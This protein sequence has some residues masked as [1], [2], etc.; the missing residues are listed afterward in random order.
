M[1]VA[2]ATAVGQSA[3][4]TPRTCSMNTR[5][6][7]LTGHQLRLFKRNKKARIFSLEKMHAFLYSETDLASIF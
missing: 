4:S 1:E 5:Y 6:F 3:T 7:L 2:C